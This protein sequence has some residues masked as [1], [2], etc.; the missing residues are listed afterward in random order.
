MHASKTIQ[1]TPQ[2]ASAAISL[3]ELR[4][5]DLT[6]GEIGVEMRAI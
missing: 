3:A 6:E 1:V 2:N 4:I 5:G